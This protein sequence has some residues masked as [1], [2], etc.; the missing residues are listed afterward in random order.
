MDREPWLA[1]VRSLIEKIIARDASAVIACSA[2][3]RS[4]RERVVVDP[5]KVKIVYL[6]GSRQLIADRIA[7]RKN[8]FMNKDLLDSQFD[9]L[10]EPRDAITVDISAP[11]QAIVESVLEKLRL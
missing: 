2:L 10:E 6:K 5:S 7:H 1:S 9:T 4:Y 8:H 3:K 11:P